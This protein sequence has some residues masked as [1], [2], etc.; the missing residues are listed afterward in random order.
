MRF[1]RPDAVPD[2]IDH[3]GTVMFLDR[4][5]VGGGVIGC[6]FA[7]FLID[8]G[9]EVHVFEMMDQVEIIDDGKEKRLLLEEVPGRG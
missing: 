8:V 7:S 2:S 6:E 9:S 5:G 4:G 1:F 3:Q